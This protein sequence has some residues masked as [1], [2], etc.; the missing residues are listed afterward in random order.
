LDLNTTHDEY[1]SLK[2]M[3]DVVPHQNTYTWTFQ[4]SSSS[5]EPVELRWDHH[6]IKSGIGQL[7]LY[8]KISEELI[9]M[10]AQGNYMVP[11]SERELQFI[12]TREELLPGLS[13]V[14]L[15]VPYPNP[16]RSEVTLPSF[17]NLTED[18]VEVWVSIRSLTGIEIYRTATQNNQRGL[19][20]PVWKGE[21]HFGQITA[22]GVYI[23]QVTFKGKDRSA[24]SYGKVIK[25]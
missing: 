20:K 12:Y 19:I 23:Y 6:R 9:D 22:D 14:N 24:M 5:K 21:D 2:F 25:H 8:D 10:R 13:K 1:F 15:G 11:A 18:P 16:F 3:R 4:L 7:L 17:I